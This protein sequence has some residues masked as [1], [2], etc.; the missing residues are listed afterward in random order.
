M[1]L[2]WHIFGTLPDSYMQQALTPPFRTPSPSAL[3]A[4]PP[5]QED[6]DAKAL[7]N[8]ASTPS[9][10]QALQPVMAASNNAG[11]IT[12][13]GMAVSPL[14]ADFSPGAMQTGGTQEV[15][16]SF[17]PATSLLD[18]SSST[19]PPLER[20]IKKVDT[21]PPA[22][23]AAAV[24]EM[25]AMINCSDRLSAS[26][27][28]TGSRAVVGE[29]LAA[30]TQ[31]RLQAR[32]FQA[33][34]SQDNSGGNAKRRRR[35]VDS[36]ALSTISR[37]GIHLNSLHRPFDPMHPLRSN[38]VSLIK[39]PY[40]KV[41]ASLEDEITEVNSRLIDT[42]VEVNAEYT[43]ELAAGGSEGVVV[44]CSYKGNAVSPNVSFVQTKEYS[45]VQMGPLFLMVPPTYPQNSPTILADQTANHA[46]SRIAG[47]TWEHF[48]RESRLLRP[49]SL[50]TM[51]KCWDECARN[52]LNE[53]AQYQGGG[54]FNTSIGNWEHIPA[55]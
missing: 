28:G 10:L 55:R 7:V 3:P 17:S 44:A 15:L 2:H 38:V 41:A 34:A 27:P 21:I 40:I 26:G 6:S 30:L 49:V 5:P 52:A 37:D 45:T 33:Q 48:K 9:S 51:A 11:A 53:A 42:V 23:L 1:S 31:A 8:A 4:T 50:G 29:D 14:M 16:Q 13:P 36:M 54:N 12:T 39:S 18:K 20:L 19:E 43:Q 24:N 22:N 46:N 47:K 35:N 32:A 25:N